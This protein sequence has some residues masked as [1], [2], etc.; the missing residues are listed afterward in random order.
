LTR[1]TNHIVLPTWP[2]D[3]YKTTPE[4]CL[5]QALAS[6]V[7]FVLRCADCGCSPDECREA[8]SAIDCPV[9]T[10]DECCCWNAV[11][12]VSDADI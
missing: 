10:L 4:L 8:P 1:V 6:K 3:V 9:C 7:R 2:Y 5:N 11:H 12:G